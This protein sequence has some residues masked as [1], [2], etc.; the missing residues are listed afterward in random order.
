MCGCALFTQIMAKAKAVKKAVAVIAIPDAVLGLAAVDG[1]PEVLIPNEAGGLVP[2]EA[3]V[4]VVRLLA[5]VN[6]LEANRV[7]MEASRV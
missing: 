1:V 2:V 7:I 3:I 6:E 4:P 5:Q